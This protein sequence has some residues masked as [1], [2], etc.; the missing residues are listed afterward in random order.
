MLIFSSAP[1]SPVI[2]VLFDL[3]VFLSKQ[4]QHF[5][6]AAKAAAGREHEGLELGLPPAPVES[7]TNSW[8]YVPL[9]HAACGTLAQP[10][11]K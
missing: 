4:R 5:P 3:S 7:A 2:C 9:R 11:A 8:L 10:V 6:A 1:V